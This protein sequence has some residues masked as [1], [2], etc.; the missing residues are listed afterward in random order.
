MNYDNS[1]IQQILDIIKTDE[2]YYSLFLDKVFEVSFRGRNKFLNKNELRFIVKSS[3]KNPCFIIQK[4]LKFSK[5]KVNGGART[6]N[7]L[8]KVLK[9]II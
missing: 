4:L 2:M 3:N 8:N 6:P 5:T 9:L 1:Y 7:Q